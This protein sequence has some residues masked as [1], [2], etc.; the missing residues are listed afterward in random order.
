MVRWKHIL[1]HWSRRSHLGVDFHLT[2]LFVLIDLC[3][4]SLALFSTIG[5]WKES[6]ERCID[7]AKKRIDKV[8]A[9]SIIT[10]VGIVFTGD[11]WSNTLFLPMNC[12][13]LAF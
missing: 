7:R 6:L 12:M 3:D 10:P 1:S 5:S 9:S 13:L 11:L 4:Y 2:K 8:V